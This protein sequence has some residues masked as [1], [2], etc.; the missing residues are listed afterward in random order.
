MGKDRAGVDRGGC[1]STHCHGYV[2]PK[3][4]TDC[5]ACGAIVMLHKPKALQQ[6]AEDIEHHEAGFAL[7]RQSDKEVRVRLE[8]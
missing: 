4:G 3:R 5:A 7:A 8:C 6:L 2:I 1:A